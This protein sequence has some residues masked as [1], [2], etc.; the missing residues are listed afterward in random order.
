MRDGSD[1]RAH[2]ILSRL[3]SPP[4]RPRTV[5]PPGKLPPTCHNCNVSLLVTE[6]LLACMQS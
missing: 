5:R 4:E 1:M 6:K 3:F 2:A